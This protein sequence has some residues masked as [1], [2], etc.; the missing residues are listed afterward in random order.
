MATLWLRMTRINSYI[1]NGRRIIVDSAPS[2]YSPKGGTGGRA[3]GELLISER[4]VSEIDAILDRGHDVQI[5]RKGHGIVV[6]EVEKK[7]K[8][9]T[10]G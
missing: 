7:I 5:R 6:L 10:Y 3:H 2:E 8:F 9:E 1:K 4:M